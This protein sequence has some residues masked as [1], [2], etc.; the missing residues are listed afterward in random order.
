M[1]VWMPVGRPMRST[2]P[3]TRKSMP[4]F[5]ALRR[6][7]L[8]FREARIATKMAERLWVMVVA[9]A[10]PATPMGIQTMKTASRTTFSSPQITSTRKGER[11]S[12]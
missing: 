8:S 12:P 3:S 6:S 9:M 2:L 5:R 7:T 1:T 11:E 10:T 4:S